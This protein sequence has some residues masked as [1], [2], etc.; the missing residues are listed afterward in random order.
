MSDR[1]VILWSFF[2][3]LFFLLSF[4][5]YLF[6]A[7]TLI[8]ETWA[9]CVS[10]YYHRIGWWMGWDTIC[11]CLYYVMP[12]E[13]CDAGIAT[14]QQH[15][16]KHWRCSISGALCVCA[17]PHN[18][19]ASKLCLFLLFFRAFSVG[20]CHTKIHKYIIIHMSVVGG[21]REVKEGVEDG[22]PISNSIKTNRKRFVF[23]FGG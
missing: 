7:F 1:A 4:V 23:F 9:V 2:L 13:W 17:V 20:F 8:Y 10:E 19:S 5:I 16:T 14:P 15:T 11:V 3:F 12:C 6:S 18:T 21:R 22:K